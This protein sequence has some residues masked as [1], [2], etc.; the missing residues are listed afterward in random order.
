MNDSDN[1][2]V[3]QAKPTRQIDHDTL[4]NLLLYLNEKGIDTFVPMHTPRNVAYIM[5]YFD[6][7]TNDTVEA[8]SVD[9]RVIGV[10]A[11]ERIDNCGNYIDLG[12]IEQKLNEIAQQ[13]NTATLQKE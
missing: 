11:G 9:G 2:T 8:Y 5:T 4:V 12:A 6:P 10:E 3:Y 7:R 1:L 13:Q